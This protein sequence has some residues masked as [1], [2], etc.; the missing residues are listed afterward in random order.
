MSTLLGEHHDAGRVHLA[1]ADMNLLEF[2]QHSPGHRVLRAALA[3]A[4]LVE[5]VRALTNATMVA[6]TDRAFAKLG[7]DANEFL[8]FPIRSF[9]F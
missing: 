2:I 3:K 9:L 6:P 4:N 1:S 8:K 7:Y 5:S